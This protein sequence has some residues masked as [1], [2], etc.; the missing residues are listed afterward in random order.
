MKQKLLVNVI[1]AAE[2]ALIQGKLPLFSHKSIGPQ[3]EDDSAPLLHITSN[4]KH[5]PYNISQLPGLWKASQFTGMN[6]DVSQKKKVIVVVSQCN[7]PLH[8]MQDY[9]VNGTFFVIIRIYI[10]SKCGEQ[11]LGAPEGAVVQALS[12]VGREGHTYAYFITDILPY[13]VGVDSSVAKQRESIV[14]FLKDTTWN[15]HG[16]QLEELR[17][18]ESMVRLASS[19]NGFGCFGSPPKHASAYHNITM[20]SQFEIDKYDSGY[21]TNDNVLFKSSHAN[22]GAYWLAINVTLT[23]KFVPVCYGGRFAASVENIY[24]QDMKMW[25]KLEVSLTRGDNIE[26]GHFV[27]RSWAALLSNPLDLVQMDAIQ[28]YTTEIAGFPM[29]GMLASGR[30]W[31]SD[32]GRGITVK[33]GEEMQEDPMKL[34]SE[35]EL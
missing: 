16:Q 32:E 34:I 10:I 24:K 3:K 9:I 30:G 6:S 12:N 18:L 20:L 4:L 23:Q 22:L 1:I 8:W 26:E 13:E 29:T 14:V 11:P 7:R 17:N 15:N 27:E 31:W 28:N 21:S 19:S 2:I 25:R 5:E 33:L 35:E